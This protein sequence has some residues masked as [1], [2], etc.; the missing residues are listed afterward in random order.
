MKLDTHLGAPSPE[1][2]ERR[3]AKTLPSAYDGRGWDP[4]TIL[5]RL[6]AFDTTNPPGNEGP[7][8]AYIDG[9][10]RQ[11]GIVTR[12]LA[13]DP[14]RPNLLAR[15][16]GRGEAS[17]LLMYGHVDVVTTEGQK[18]THPPF[19]GTIANGYVWGR[20][21]L[22]MKGGVAMMVAALLQAKSQGLRPAGDI[23]LAIVADE[24]DGSDAGAR[25]LVEQHPE[26]FEGV[27]YAI[28]EFGG[29]TMQIG[30]HTFYPIM[31]A[32]RQMCWM[33][34]RLKGRGGH[35]SIPVKG[36]AMARLA[37]LLRRLDGRRLPVHITEPAR[38]MFTH[39]ADEMG[40]LAGLTIRLMLRPALTDPIL[41]L[42]NGQARLF[43]PLLHNTVSPTTLSGSHKINVIPSDVEVGLDGRLLPG[44]RPENLVAELQDLL[45]SEVDLQ[46]VRSDRV[47]QPPDM[48]LF[49][50]LADILREADPEGVPI[51]YL[52]A[53]TTDG[54]YFSDLGIQTYGFVP[55]RLPA[56]F[57]FPAVIHAADER[58]PVE[59]MAFGTHAILELIRRFGEM[60]KDN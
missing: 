30:D 51:P 31:V 28:G 59:A 12:L 19:G 52:L 48:A 56:D 8:I 27:R 60:P 22:D 33:K 58:V 14:E 54:R 9:L 7:C 16:G 44:Q 37:A 46:V 6:I 23:I 3:A 55:V 2:G 26:Q 11:A 1:V 17:P 21:A 42:L 25:F 53:G 10:L 24:E 47:P 34:A 39:I 4:V 13:K 50:T 15:L 38:M 5:Q 32:E 20:G 49:D 41:N 36:E 18:W 43:E 29:F 40:G 57:D 45:G 35:G